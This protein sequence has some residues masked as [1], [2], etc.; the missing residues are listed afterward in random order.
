MDWFDSTKL[1]DEGVQNQAISP[2]KSIDL[3][4]GLWSASWRFRVA[5]LRAT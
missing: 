3:D 5:G 2:T 4:P 1:H